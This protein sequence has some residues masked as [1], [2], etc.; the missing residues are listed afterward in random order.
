MNNVLQTPE[1]PE[2]VY[3][4]YGAVMHLVQTWEQ[5]LS[6][7]WWRSTV[8]GNAGEAETQASKKAILRLQHA[9]QKMT[10]AEAR[11][12]LGD[13]LPAQIADQVVAL[14]PERNRLA[15]RF[16]REQQ[17]LDAFKPGTMA[18][19]EHA[20][21]KFEA[22]MEQMKGYVNSF[23]EYKGPV[24]PHW[25]QL[26]DHLADRLLAGEPIDMAEALRRSQGLT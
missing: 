10:A 17:L 25:S 22:S 26:A 14:M 4:L 6:M 18:W 20:G 23:G 1:P 15:H 2:R 9:F 16:L 5:L 19:M 8:T 21:G 12:Q 11:K 13:D 3:T 24:R 7:I